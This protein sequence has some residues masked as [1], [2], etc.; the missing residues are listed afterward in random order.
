MP[1][2]VKNAQWC[3][4]ASRVRLVLDAMTK[5]SP[6]EYA[7]AEGGRGTTAYLLAFTTWPLRLAVRL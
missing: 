1:D 7:A 2:A 4:Q 3:A 5:I 6:L